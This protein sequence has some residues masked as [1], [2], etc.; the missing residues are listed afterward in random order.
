MGQKAASDALLCA[1]QARRCG[2]SA[3]L[4]IRP[5]RGLHPLN[6]KPPPPRPPTLASTTSPTPPPNKKVKKRDFAVDRQKLKEYFPTEVGLGMRWGM[7]VEERSEME[8]PPP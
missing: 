7:D 8:P 2:G 5:V 6:P 4:V 1:C 3:D